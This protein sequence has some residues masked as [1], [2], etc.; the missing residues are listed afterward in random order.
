MMRGGLERANVGTY[1][2]LRK[3]IKEERKKMKGKKNQPKGKE[4]GYGYSL[5]QQGEGGEKT[6]FEKYFLHLQEKSRSQ[7]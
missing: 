7:K 6:K 3:R 1:R 2:L 4:A 5:G